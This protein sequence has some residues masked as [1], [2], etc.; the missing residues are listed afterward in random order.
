MI[1]TCSDISPK[2]DLYAIS[3]YVLERWSIIWKNISIEAQELS[4][5]HDTAKDGCFL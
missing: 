3:H 2:T 1:E 4:S 5:P